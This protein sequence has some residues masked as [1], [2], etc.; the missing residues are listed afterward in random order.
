MMEQTL[1]YIDDNRVNVI[2]QIPLA[3]IV[4]DFFDKLKSSTRG[5]ASFDYDMS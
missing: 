3:E 4:F 5:Y 2:Y 1:D